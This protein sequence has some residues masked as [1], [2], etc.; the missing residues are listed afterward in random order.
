MN[1][2][3]IGILSV[4]T[5]NGV[6]GLRKGLVKIVCQ[7][8][9][10]GLGIYFGIKYSPAAEV[11]V[12][13]YTSIQDP[14][15]SYIGF[16]IIWIA[17]LLGMIAL[18]IV[19]DKLV[20][21]SLLG[22]VNRIG[23]LVLGVGK[24]MLYLLPLILPLVYFDVSLARNSQLIHPIKPTLVSVMNHYLDKYLEN[25]EIPENYPEKNSESNIVTKPEKEMPDAMLKL[26]ED[27]RINLDDI[28]QEIKE[29]QR[30]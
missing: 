27:N 2:L 18:S 29:I 11:F 7:M 19:I 20:D 5:F 12:K 30:K 8:V 16:T 6:M 23:G 28:R 26:L 22:P 9:A 25:R 3:D 21:F 17:T 1:S 4:L 24:G 14:Y 13:S 15:A 10:F